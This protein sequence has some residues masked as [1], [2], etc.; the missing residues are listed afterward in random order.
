MI[1]FPVGSRLTRVTEECLPIFNVNGTMRKGQKS[2]LAQKFNFIELDFRD[3]Y[4]ALVDM[5]FI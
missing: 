4:I 1:R 3:R 5:G 2:K